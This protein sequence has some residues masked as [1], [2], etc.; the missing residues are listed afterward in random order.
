[1][2]HLWAVLLLSCAAFG[3]VT[4]DN[5]NS[6]SNFTVTSLTTS[7][8]T[9]SSSANRAAIVALSFS[10]NTATSISVTVGGVSGTLI[11]GTD[12]GTT[13][14]GR[15]VLY[16]VKSPAS[17]AQ[18]ASASWTGSMSFATLGVWTATGVDQTSACNN[19][20]NA[21]FNSNPSATISLSITSISGD[22]TVAVGYDFGN[23]FNASSPVTQDWN[24]STGV[25]IGT[26]GTG[27][28]TQTHSFTDPFA[29]QGEV[30]SGANFIAAGAAVSVLPRRIVWF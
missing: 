21:G 23:A 13:A 29:G 12:T 20:T 22:L 15:T 24:I 28:G 2:R 9:I 30:A 8:F 14:T 16:C 3:A 11:A 6:T 17:G 5:K 27:T 18:T 19:G 1:M 25:V 7:S 26:H 10:A 4:F